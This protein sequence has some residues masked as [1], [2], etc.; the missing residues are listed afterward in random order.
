MAIDIDTGDMYVV[1]RT[2]NDNWI[3]YG[4]TT[5]DSARHV[6]QHLTA[7]DLG[8]DKAELSYIA[9]HLGEMYVSDA[10]NDCVHILTNSGSRKQ[11]VGQ[12]GRGPG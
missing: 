2:V 1:S 5:Y 10:D 4:I 8:V 6:T 3:K 9:L 12:H 11:R 7:A